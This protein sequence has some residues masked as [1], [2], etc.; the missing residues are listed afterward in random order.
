MANLG[1][2]ICGE[3]LKYIKGCD[4][5]SYEWSPIESFEREIDSIFSIFNIKKFTII[6]LDTHKIMY[7]TS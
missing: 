3:Y 5:V 4:F 2:E 7:Y 6:S 1:E